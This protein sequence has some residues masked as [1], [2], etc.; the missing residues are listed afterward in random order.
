M[1]LGGG[2]SPFLGIPVYCIMLTWA[3]NIKKKILVR[4][5]SNAVYVP[6]GAGHMMYAVGLNTIPSLRDPWQSQSVVARFTLARNN[7]TPKTR[8]MYWQWST[9]SLALWDIS[10]ECCWAC[11]T[12]RYCCGWLWIAK[13]CHLWNYFFKWHHN[14]SSFLQFWEHVCAEVQT[15]FSW[16]MW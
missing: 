9:Q 3:I 5:S 14:L 4:A 8:Y 15:P 6:V 2:G 13:I 16:Y 1:A 10:R 12:Y 7:W 11:C